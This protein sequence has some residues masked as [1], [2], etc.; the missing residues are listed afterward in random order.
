MHH[1]N[2]LSEP[3]LSLFCI[4]CECIKDPY[5]EIVLT[6]SDFVLRP[7]A[8]HGGVFTHNEHLYTFWKEKIANYRP[9]HH[10]GYSY[11]I[12]VM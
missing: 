2:P 8:E 3:T 1:I 5:M 7:Q 12:N 11:D 9:I 6:F 4:L 10:T